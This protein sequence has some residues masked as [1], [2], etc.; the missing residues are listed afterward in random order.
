MRLFST[1]LFALLISFSTYAQIPSGYYNKAQGLTGSELKDSLYQIIKGHTTFPYTSSSTDVWDILQVT[2]QDPN[3]SQ[4]VLLLYTGRSEPKSNMA[5]G[6]NASN[7]NYWNR[8]H[9]W[10]KSHGGFNNS[11]TPGT[12]VHHLRPTDQSV[13]ADRGNLDFD[14]GGTTHPEA[15]GCKYDSDSWEPRDAVKGDVARMIFYMATRY[16]G[17]NGEP[18]LEV[19]DLTGNGFIPFHGKLTTLVQWHNQDT[20]DAF[21]RNRNNVIY[22]SYQGNRNPYIDHPEYVTYIFDS[23][24]VANPVKPEPTNHVT[25][26]RR[27]HNLSI[28]WTDAQGTAAPDGY[29]VKISEV[30]FSAITPPTDGTVETTTATTKVVAQGVESCLFTGLEGGTTYY[31]KIFPFKGSGNQ[32]NYKTTGQVPQLTKTTP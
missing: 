23:N 18:D 11:S 30:G 6:A 15:T 26:F 29:V 3:N 7:Q 16:E 25:N 21:E 1:A 22:N 5:S 27:L 19:N 12:D 28:T 4:N 8:E 32:I 20:V 10:A 31:F 17:E 13:N 9:V 2:D 14:N 24:Y